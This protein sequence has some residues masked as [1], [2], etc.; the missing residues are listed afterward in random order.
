MCALHPDQQ[1][2]T[3][4][5]ALRAADFA[6]E[7]GAL[8]CLQL[9]TVPE[10]RAALKAMGCAAPSSAN[11]EQVVGVLRDAL[12]SP[13]AAR[14]ADQVTHTAL[15]SGGEHTRSCCLYCAARSS[16]NLFLSRGTIELPTKQEYNQ[17]AS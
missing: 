14:D 11:R 10:L 9:L 15:Q 8:C 1:Y 2:P 3:T 12:A 13:D 17:L 5:R 4:G 6:P 7:R 16:L